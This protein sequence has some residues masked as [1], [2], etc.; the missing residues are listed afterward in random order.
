MP[1]HTYR[2]VPSN[3][4]EK[5]YRCKVIGNSDAS[6][7]VGSSNTI[8]HVRETSGSGFILGLTKKT[9]GRIKL[10]KRYDLRYDDRRM[11]VMAEKYESPVGDEERLLVSTYREYEPKERWAFRLPFTKGGKVNTHESVISSGAAYGGFV[12]VLFCVMSLPGIGDRLGTAPRIES[13]LKLMGDNI[14][15]IVETVRGK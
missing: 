8:V 3:A 15:D 7:Q 13:A 10:G 4:V 11:Q 5:V 12:L 6:L 2:T 9:A 14:L 1:E